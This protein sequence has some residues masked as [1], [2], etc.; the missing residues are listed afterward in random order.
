MSSFLPFHIG[1]SNQ[2]RKGLTYSRIAIAQL[3]T[4]LQLKEDVG[5]SFHLIFDGDAS[6]L[7]QFISVSSNKREKGL[8]KEATTFTKYYYDLRLPTDKQECDKKC[9][10]C[11]RMP[12]N[13]HTLVLI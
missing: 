9:L 5:D 7:I 3:F 10:G 12:L 13:G 8:R 2:L 6:V 4:F 11:Q 1:V